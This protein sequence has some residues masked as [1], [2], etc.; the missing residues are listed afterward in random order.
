LKPGKVDGITVGTPRYPAAGKKKFVFAEQPLAV[1]EGEVPINLNLRAGKSSSAGPRSL[2][3]TLT[4]QACDE[5]KCYPPTTLNA[6]V[7]VT[8]K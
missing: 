5:E 8:V 6:T 7:P 4:V 1:Y 2:P 3:I